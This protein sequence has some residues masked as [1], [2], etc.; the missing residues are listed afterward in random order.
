MQ[1]LIPKTKHG[2]SQLAAK[3]P[4]NIQKALERYVEDICRI[5]G[6]RLK[7]V[8]L[9]G[10]YARGDFRQDSDIDIMIL[11]DLPEEEIRRKGQSLSDITFEYNFDNSLQIMPVVKNQRHF[12][13]WLRAY[14]FY[15]YVNNEG[16][17][18]YAG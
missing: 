13:K 14:P 17:E 2:Q 7:T 4:L 11:V 6:D 12:Q 5:Y 9:Y 3:C 1:D 10:S 16:V 18:L 15:N 8:L